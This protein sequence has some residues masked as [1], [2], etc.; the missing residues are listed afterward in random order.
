MIVVGYAGD[1]TPLACGKVG[2]GHENRIGRLESIMGS[3][4]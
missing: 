4:G 3:R 2:L 1:T